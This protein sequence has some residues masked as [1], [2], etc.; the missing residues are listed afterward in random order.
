MLYL[1]SPAAGKFVSEVLF[2]I[3]AWLMMRLR[4]IVV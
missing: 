3:A 4:K 1:S 2:K